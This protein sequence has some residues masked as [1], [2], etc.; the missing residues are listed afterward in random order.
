METKNCRKYCKYFVSFQ[1]D[2]EDELKP[3]DY[4]FCHN[5]DSG[6]ETTGWDNWGFCF[7]QTAEEN[8]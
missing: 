8:K 2:Y 3:Y 5:E 4:G 1:I 7:Y 6:V